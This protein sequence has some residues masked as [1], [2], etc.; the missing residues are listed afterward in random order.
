L[1]RY[2]RLAGR[3]TVAWGDV[4]LMPSAVTPAAVTPALAAAAL[5]SDAMIAALR[6]ADWVGDRT[7]VTARGLLGRGP[8]GQACAALGIDV[9]GLARDWDTAVSAGLIVVAGS[10][11]SA[12]RPRRPEDALE[13]WLRALAVPL[14]R[15]DDECAQWLAAMSVLASAEDESFT[16]AAVR[17]AAFG[18]ADDENSDERADQ[19]LA[20]W[21]S[22]G[23]V[24]AG[25][26]RA[27]GGGLAAGGPLRI[28][29]L[30]RLLADSVTAMLAPAPDDNADV[31]VARFSTLPVRVA[32]QYAERWL[33]ARTP[34]AAAAEL[35]DFAGTAT[36]RERAIA[37]DLAAE[38]GPDA[39]PAWRD[40]AE[41]PGYGAYIREWLADQGEDVPEF[42][43]DEAWMAAEM[44]ALALDE[45]SSCAGE[46]RAGEEKVAWAVEEAFDT[47]DPVT[48]LRESGHPD[49][50]QLIDL[51]EGPSSRRPL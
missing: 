24:A 40:R 21:I 34:V 7:S 33:A 11:A 44:F 12:V 51:I 16:A 13:A 15:S 4:D 19:W 1:A 10:R 45:A 39:A 36:P 8:A 38:I 47:D 22:F 48:V 20:D 14:G 49:A 6:L 37:I 43:A 35:I 26:G 31:I 28:T 5:A 27:A 29:P 2:G 42:P 23:A 41:R 46:S 17:D 30:G 25:G 3:V 50:A 18:A 9:P 32:I